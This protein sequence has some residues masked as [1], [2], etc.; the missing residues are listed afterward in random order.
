MTD[1]L[2]VEKIYEPF[3]GAEY[4]IAETC[5]LKKY[6]FLPY[7]R[8]Y[9][10]LSNDE[11]QRLIQTARECHWQALDLSNCGLKELP[12]ELWSLTD[13]RLLYLGNHS[14]RESKRG[15]PNTISYLPRAIEQLTKLNVLS[16]AGLTLSVEGEGHLLLNHLVH[17]E[18]FDSHY[19]VYPEAFVIPSL[20]GLAVSGLVSLPDS[21]RQLSKLIDLYLNDCAFTKLPEWFGFLSKLRILSLRNSRIENLPMSMQNLCNI[22]DLWISGTP[23]GEKIPGEIL[24][25]SGQEIIQYIM[26]IQDETPKEFF[27]ESKMIIVG[28]PQVGKSSLLERL[29]YGSYTDKPST[30]GINIKPWKFLCSGEEYRLNLWDFGGQEI[31]HSTHQFFLTQRSLYILVWDALSEDEYGRIDYWLRTIQSFAD[32]CPIFIVVNKCDL[33]NGRR[34]KLYLEDYKIRYPQIVDICEVSCRDNYGIDDLRRK[35]QQ[36]AVNLPLMKTP[37]LTAWLRVR[38]KLENLSKTRNHIPYKRYLNICHQEGLSNSDS[39]SLAKYLHDLGVILYY[40]DDLLLR[41]MVILSSEWGT[42]AVYKI[43]DEQEQQLKGRNGI[44]YPSK[45]LDVIW[46]DRKRYPREYHQHLLNLMVNF[47]LSFRIDMDT[48]L[49]AEL[50]EDKAIRLDLPFEFGETLCFRLDYDFLPAGIMTRFIVA[51]HEKLEILDGV[52]QCWKKGAYLRHGSA[53]ALIQLFDTPPDRHVLI[54]VSG[55]DS[56]L[57]QELLTFIRIELEK[58]N[59]LFNKINIS[60]KIPCICKCGCPTLFKYDNLVRA[61]YESQSTIQCHESF[62]HVS[63][64]KLLDGVK[65]IMLY[66]PEKYISINNNIYNQYTP[67]NT[68]V[69]TNSNSN[70]NTNTNSITISIE[71]KDLINGFHGDFNDLRSE[72]QDADFDI[73]CEKVDTALKTLD[74]CQTEDEMKRSGA[75]KKLERFLK[76]CHNP[77]SD[78]GKLLAGVKYAG[79]IALDLGKKYNKL[80]SLLGAP[81]IPLIGT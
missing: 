20:K 81:S 21:F 19:D 41:N 55:P 34:K 70:D 65:P 50:L 46:T 42:D 18:L 35:I 13:L 29:I 8:K 11:L 32:E 77:E 73:Q 6:D 74:N 36:I 12:D 75:M 10:N 67:G 27:N 47:R 30:E 60:Q 69:A 71:I 49:V 43:L 23:L 17:L 78:T 26:K 25:Q 39:L 58:V 64:R 54:R 31:Y 22:Q 48:Y 5:E 61:E 68:A 79:D 16:L 52:R 63:I 53:Y 44:L 56:R 24:K 45:D 76:E 1:L 72:V 3:D 59:A 62:Q 2:W 66:D 40:H 4:S 7:N 28:Q 33:E 80:A 37:W 15:N 57:R 38:V 14:F 51:A 9:K